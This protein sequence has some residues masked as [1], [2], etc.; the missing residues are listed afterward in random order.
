MS[1]GRSRFFDLS[2][3][4]LI[5]KWN[6]NEWE[7]KVFDSPCQDWFMNLSEHLLVQWR[8]QKLGWG[9]GG[10]STFGKWQLRLLT[11]DRDGLEYIVRSAKRMARCQ[12]FDLFLKINNIVYV[13]HP[14]AVLP[15]VR[16]SDG[17]VA[18][19]KYGSRCCQ[20]WIYENVVP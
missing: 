18:K 20:L 14:I 11:V 2:L 10:S 1:K 19:K 12:C 6:H 13:K 7:Y 5:P 17:G 15:N 4:W 3:K 8:T 9:G 16:V